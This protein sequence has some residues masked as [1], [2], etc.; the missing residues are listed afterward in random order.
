MEKLKNKFLNMKMPHTYVILTIILLSVVLLTYIIPAGEYDRVYDPISDKMIVISDSF[1]YIEGIRPGF[2]DI[3]LSM[4]HGYVSAANIIFL[5]LFAYGYVYMLIDNGTLN[6]AITFLVNRLGNNS[7]FMIPISMLVFGILGSTMGIFEEVYGLVPVFIGISVGLGYDILVGGAI[8]I[9]GVATGFAAATTN[10]FSIGIA[11]SIAG[12]PMF[13]GLGYR[14]IVFIVF[15]MVSIIYVMMYAKKVKDNP[16]RSAV[17]GEEIDILP[18]QESQ[19]IK[20][21]LSQK[22]SLLMFFVTIVLLLYGTTQLNWYIDEIAA[23]F[24]MMMII[25]GIVGRYSAT[26]IC[27]T[28]IESTKSMVSSIL[29]IGFTRAILIIMQEA[30]ISDTI[31]NYLSR[32]LYNQNKYYSS[33]GMLIIQN[34][35]N[36]F[37]TGSSSQATITMPIMASVSDIIGISRQTAVLVYQFG[38]GFSDL[39]WP[40]A[41]SLTCGLMGVPLNK[42]YKFIAP[43]FLIMVV[44]QVI[45]TII[46]VSIFI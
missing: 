33:V 17:Y 44:L 32:M 11:Q 38:D 39:F 5:I 34:I 37:I 45:F 9:V 13:S 12:V 22:I 28:F 8:V 20:M 41:C 3:F 6:G 2:F 16:V 4:Q 18:F 7:H 40:T 15:Q 31:V 27:K 42:W 25:T 24:L 1:H 21:T 30:M 43:L 29:V 26:H 46:S 10:P 35:I 14:I 23:M 36:F 19:D